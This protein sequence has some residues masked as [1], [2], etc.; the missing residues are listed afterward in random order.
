MLVVSS[1]LSGAFPVA[2]PVLKGPRH[3]GHSTMAVCA[4]A[5]AAAEATREAIS[6]VIDRTG[7]EP[8]FDMSVAR[9]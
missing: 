1:H 5:I 9:L 3:W 6:S 2:M 8:M 7:R 4:A